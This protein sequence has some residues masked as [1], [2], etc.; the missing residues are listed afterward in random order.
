MII[1]IIILLLLALILISLG[2]GMVSLIKDRGETNRTVKFLTI[3]IVLSIA[4]FVLLVVSF[5][6]GWIQPHGVLPTGS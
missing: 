1:K 4:L 6:M 2:A 3:R 5:L